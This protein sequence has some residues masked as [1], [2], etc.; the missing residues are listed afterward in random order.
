VDIGYSRAKSS[1]PANLFIA[2]MK[3][4]GKRS[5]SLLLGLTWRIC[6][7]QTRSESPLTW[8]YRSFKATRALSTPARNTPR[9]G[10]MSLAMYEFLTIG[11]VGTLGSDLSPCSFYATRGVPCIHK[12]DFTEKLFTLNIAHGFSYPCFV[13]PSTQF[14][15]TFPEPLFPYSLFPVSSTHT[16]S[17]AIQYCPDIITV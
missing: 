4:H 16:S 17:S 5:A 12:L 14:L 11:Y 7:N 10:Q 13:S 6:G 15:R 9:L 3:P 8:K 1:I 2:G